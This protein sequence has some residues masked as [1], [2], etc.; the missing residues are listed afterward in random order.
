M[1]SPM[2]KRTSIQPIHR[3]FDLPIE[4]NVDWGVPTAW[5]IA[6]AGK[7]TATRTRATTTSVGGDPPWSRVTWNQRIRIEMVEPAAACTM[8]LSNVSTLASVNRRPTTE[9]KRPGSALSNVTLPR[10]PDFLR[11][12]SHDS[13]AASLEV[14]PGSRQ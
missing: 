8:S 5:P 11:G 13:C 3:L 10:S 12:S 6:H 2:R 14:A 1:K 7:T 4:A 9:H